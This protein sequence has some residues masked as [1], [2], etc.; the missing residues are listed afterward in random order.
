M[1]DKDTK[2]QTDQHKKQTNE[3]KDRQ[4]EIYL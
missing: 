3:Q 2:R 1:A 4:D